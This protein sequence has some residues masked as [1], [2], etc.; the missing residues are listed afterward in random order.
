MIIQQKLNGLLKFDALV[1]KV[2][3]VME[4]NGKAVF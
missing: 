1:K 3:A 2:Q 4:E